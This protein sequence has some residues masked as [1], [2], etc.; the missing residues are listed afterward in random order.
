MKNRYSTIGVLLKLQTA[1]PFVMLFGSDAFDQS[2]IAVSL[3]LILSVVLTVLEG[4]FLDRDKF[5][6]LMLPVVATCITVSVCAVELLLFLSEGQLKGPISIYG[7]W[8]T[9]G[10]MF[11][12][13]LAL[14]LICVWADRPKIQQ[15]IQSAINS[16][17]S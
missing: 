11:V 6:R 8:K 2:H 5:K 16:D 4:L 17:V 3:V 14:G 12:I 7:L 9:L 13:F 15:V 1:A 10:G